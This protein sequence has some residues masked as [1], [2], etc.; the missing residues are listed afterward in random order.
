VKNIEPTMTNQSTTPPD[1]PAA[2]EM[3]P[4]ASPFVTEFFM[5]QGL[6]F[7]G[8]AYCGRDG[9]WRD[10]FRHHPLMGRIFILE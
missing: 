3:R 1:E 2:G 9:K 4:E 5:V 6:T 10:A 8:M 7:H